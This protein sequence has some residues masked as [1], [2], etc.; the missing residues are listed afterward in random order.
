MI[1]SAA[2]GRGIGRGA[3][4]MA[5]VLGFTLCAG[6]AFA[7]DW[8]S[9]QGKDVTLFYPGQ[10]SWEWVLTKTDHSGAPKF[11]EGKNCRGCH[12]GEEADIGNLI[13]SGKK[14]EPTP[15]AGKRGAIPV[16]VRTA[17]DG[18]KLYIRLQWQAQDL[19][20]A[21]RMDPDYATKVTVMLDDGAI[22]EAGRAGC[23]GACHDDADAMASSQSG[24]EIEKYLIR[25]RTKMSRQGGGLNFK[26]D[27]DL[28]KMAA[29]GEFFEFWQARLNPGAPARAVHGYILK[30]RT[31]TTPTVV[32]ATAQFQNGSWTVV[33]S[34]PLKAGGPH[35]KALEAG[36]TYAMGFAI[37]DAHAAK[38]FH[39]VSFEHTLSLNAGSTD[40]VARQQ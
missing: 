7:V 19:A 13:V 27:A 38:R 20:G 1:R 35:H 21:P 30:D 9:V 32:E 8:E 39:H 34:R 16:N 11:R 18:Q 36:K 17:H 31:E 23:W 22:T 10:A 12:Q 33:L 37:H 24:R 6:S 3:L 25:S 14:L 15:V 28:A 40:F 4:S 5:S 29:G 2:Q 26:P